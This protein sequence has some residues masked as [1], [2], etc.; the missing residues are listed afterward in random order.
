MDDDG[1]SANLD[2][3][4]TRTIPA[5][6]AREVIICGV[7]GSIIRWYAHRDVTGHER[8]SDVDGPVIFVANHC[9]HVDTPALLASLPGRFRRRT[10][11]AAAADYFYARQVLAHAVSLAFCTVPLERRGGGVSAE[12]TSHMRGLIADGWSLVVFA[13]GTRSRD[14]RVARLRSGAAVLAAEHGVPIVPVHVGGTHAAMP[15]GSGW[16]SRPQ[17]GGRFGRHAIPVSFGPPIAVTADDDRLE[18]MEQ[19]RLFMASCG[20][21]TTPD[22][23]L[24]ARRAAMAT[25]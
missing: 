4:W 9:S 5:R 11:V 20:A 1:A 22:P 15:S 6:V 16:M 12:A 24:A 21:D 17:D 8:L 7:F 25:V 13:E 23:N 2:Q 10:A 14:G 3:P 19:V 18:I